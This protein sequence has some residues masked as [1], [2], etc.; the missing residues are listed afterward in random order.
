MGCAWTLVAVLSGHLWKTS[1]RQT[2][3]HSSAAW[4]SPS[5]CAYESGY[6]PSSSLEGGSPLIGVKLIEY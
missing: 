5:V 3:V 1:L 2:V 6:H 4:T